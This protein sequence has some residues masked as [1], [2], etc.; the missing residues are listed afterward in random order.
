M[1]PG[2]GTL[3]FEL[4]NDLAEMSVL[5]EHLEQF[6]AGHGLGPEV[7]SQLNLALDEIVTHIIAHGYRDEGREHRIR[8][9]LAHDGASV[10]ARIE[11]DAAAF[12][13]LER[14]DPTQGI[15]LLKTLVDEV[16]YS[17]ERGHNA[18][19]VRKTV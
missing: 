7:F 4:T 1:T 8:I 11:D 13:P 16:T 18:L 3:S 12:D 17:R 19:I 6:C 5:A 15:N 2:H 10:T 14:D 9:T